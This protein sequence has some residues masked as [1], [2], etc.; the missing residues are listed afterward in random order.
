MAN[1]T[2]ADIVIRDS[3]W[4]GGAPLTKKTKVL[5][6]TLTLTSQGI[7]TAG[8]QIPASAFGLTTIREVTPLQKSDNT[9]LA[10]AAPSY[11]GSLI[12]TYDNSNAT[13]ATRDAPVALT[14]TFRCLVKGT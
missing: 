13:D 14:G 8:S 6:V 3:W 11:D 10:P 1:L 9:I 12:L 2:K 5:S 7:A 4:E